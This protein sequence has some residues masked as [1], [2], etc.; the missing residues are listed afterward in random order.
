MPSCYTSRPHQSIRQPTR[1][2]QGRNFL[3]ATA[4]SE[5]LYPLSRTS[6]ARESTASDAAYF[7][8]QTLSPHYLI[9][10]M[11]SSKYGHYLAVLLTIT[12]F[13]SYYCDPG[14]YG[15]IFP[16]RCNIVYQKYI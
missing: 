16:H 11:A 3:H 6:T 10:I 4:P 2:L 15:I 9:P 5:K 13:A 14:I 7:R 1:V 8:V 12:Q